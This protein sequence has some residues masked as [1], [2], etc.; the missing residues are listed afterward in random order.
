MNTFI[1][2]LTIYMII[3]HYSYNKIKND[4][5]ELIRYR[6]SLVRFT[7]LQ[8]S[9]SLYDYLSNRFTIIGFFTKIMFSHIGVA[10]FV[11]V[12]EYLDK[13]VIKKK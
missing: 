7:F 2:I 13:I 11:L 8:F 10:S 4:K 9:F 3:M 5:I 1:I 12:K 6:D